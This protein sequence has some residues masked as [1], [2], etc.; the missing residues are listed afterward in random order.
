MVTHP[1]TNRA[2]RWLTSLI[3]PT[4]LTVTADTGSWYSE[5]LYAVVLCVC[6]S[7][8]RVL[9]HV[10]KASCAETEPWMVSPSQLAQVHCTLLIIGN[11]IFVSHLFSY[12]TTQQSVLVKYRSCTLQVIMVAIHYVWHL[13]TDGVPTVWLFTTSVV[14][15]WSVVRLVVH[16]PWMCDVWCLHFNDQI[17]IV[18]LF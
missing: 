5:H 7:E 11:G 4:L 17:R 15:S 10:K 6:V 12:C 18:Q 9:S 1:S 3:Q 16:A 8:W 2:R 13:T 14:G